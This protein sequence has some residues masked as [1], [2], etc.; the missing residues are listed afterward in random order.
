M[1]L[2][3]L[4]SKLL[5][6]FL[7]GFAI[8]CSRT[9]ALWTSDSGRE[10]TGRTG[11]G[12]NAADSGQTGEKADGNWKTSF[13]QQLEEAA[14]PQEVGDDIC[15]GCRAA[16]L[17]RRATPEELDEAAQLAA[18]L[19]KSENW[20][21]EDQIAATIIDVLWLVDK[22]RAVDVSDLLLDAEGT[23]GATRGAAARVL[24]D[25]RGKAVLERLVKALERSPDQFEFLINPIHRAAVAS[26]D[27]SFN[28]VIA[29]LERVEGSTNE[30][31]KRRS[32]A[33]ERD[34]FER[35]VKQHGKADAGSGR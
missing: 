21:R 12:L 2:A 20:S 1:R 28:R 11:Q 29:A 22:R 3:L 35:Q 31:D 24:V 9:T 27:S 5:V 10:G 30:L 4:R 32:V 34:W 17:L 25:S 13:Q 19:S 14:K 16:R 33:H 6:V 23:G 26:G 18:S 7:A 8:S 15:D